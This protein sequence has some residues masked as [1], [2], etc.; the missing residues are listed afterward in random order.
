MCRNLNVSKSGYYAWAKH[1]PSQRAQEDAVL[2]NKISQ[3]HKESRGTYGSPRVAND[4]Q[5][6]GLD[7]GRRRVARLMRENGI[8]GRPQKLFKVTTDSNHE[9]PVADNVLERNFNQNAPDAAWVTDISYIRTWEGWLYLAV[10]IDVFSRRVIG[11]SMATHMRSELVQDALGMALGSRIPI[12]NMIHHSDRGSQYASNAYRDTLRQHGIV[13]SMSRRA[14]C[15]DNAV[16]ESFFATL[17]KELIHRRPWPTVAEARTAIAEYIEVFYNRK[18]KHSTLG[19]VSPVEFERR[20]HQD[21]RL[22]A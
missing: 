7:V 13:C 9:F 16:A 2:V 3:V 21:N 8:S 5:E 17:K 15:W 14:D 4:L 19:Y 20:Y 11:W 1:T 18:R 10:V 12:P 6:Q 22:A